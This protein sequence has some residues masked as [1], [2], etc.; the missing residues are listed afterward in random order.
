MIDRLRGFWVRLRRMF[1][2]RESDG[3]LAA[4]M[5]SH[6][7]QETA[8]RI[9]TGEHP[10]T[11]RRRAAAEFGS[12]D[13]RT[14]EVRDARMGAW[15]DDLRIDLRY[16]LR[17]LR[18]SPTF[19]VVTVLILTLGIGS[20]ATIFSIVNEVLWRD[21]PFA[22]S[23]RVVRVAATRKEDGH[24]ANQT[25]SGPLIHAWRER[26]SSFEY[27]AIFS[28]RTTVF[29]HNNRSPRQ[30]RALV[31]SPS[32]YDIVG[33]P[34]QLGR[35]LT[36]EDASPGAEAVAVLSHETWVTDFNRDPSVLDRH[37]TLDAQSHRVIGVLSPEAFLTIL[38]RPEN[39]DF[40]L[41]FLE[42]IERLNRGE[43]YYNVVAKLKPG[44]TV[45]SAHAEMLAVAERIQTE[46]PELSEESLT[47]VVSLQEDRNRLV[48]PAL[49]ATVTLVALLLIST[50]VNGVKLTLVRTISR[51]GE[52]SV[53]SA[54]GASRGRLT[55]QLLAET[56]LLAVLGSI[57]GVLLA[58]WGVNLL[59]R[60]GPPA[61]TAIARFGFDRDAIL[62]ALVVCALTTF[63]ITAASLCR[64][65]SADQAIDTAN[66]ST[67]AGQNQNRLLNG[68]MTAQFAIATAVLVAAGLM[69]V[70]FVRLTSVDPGFQT[71]D[72]LSF[73]ITLPDTDYT[74]HETRVQMFDRIRGQ[75]AALP[76][77][78][79]VT[80]SHAP[81]LSGHS[82]GWGWWFIDGRGEPEP[83]PVQARVVLDDYHATMGIDLIRGRFFDR[84]D[85][86]DASPVV[87][88]NERLAHNH[89]GEEDAIGRSIQFGWQ[90][91]P[92]EVIGIVH[93]V[94]H[95]SLRNEIKAM[96]YVP[97]GQLQ[98]A[99]VA[100]MS[101]V[102]RGT[103]SPTSLVSSISSIVAGIDPGLPLAEVALISDW[104]R[105]AVALEHSILQLLLFFSGVTVLITAVGLYGVVSYLMR[106]RRRELGIRVAVGAQRGQIAALVYQQGARIVLAG[107]AL[108]IFV[109][110]SGTRIISNLLY[111]VDAFA[112][113]VYLG[114]GVVLIT[115]ASIALGLPAWRAT[116]IN[117]TEA[118]RSE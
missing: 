41:P 77:V 83:K 98:T 96:I 116:K 25:T 117:P 114:A 24:S 17:G 12:V 54:L 99:D 80:G 19:S 22:D 18:K 42:P 38:P 108:G 87:I 113:V 36:A 55:R 106:Q 115:A 92:M 57:G 26:T 95:F 78:T 84:R 48:R 3:G 20:A 104:V 118:L 63:A 14:E 45:D 9:A 109:A 50:V 46:R 33:L 52:F 67:T 28:Q 89:F 7:E 8:R 40:L 100:V 64:V 53:R 13:A 111:D 49:W 79:A 102:V 10:A 23:D 94:Q 90:E 6:L 97:A 39:T 4:E 70:S 76:G 93:N 51:E 68:L 1:F 44:V 29:N 30:A 91:K 107:I 85:H 105:E 103:G 15:F 112:P 34:M 2:R 86:A 82:E 65:R 16:A 110:W 32:L 59:A 75:T 81:P 5:Q 71:E 21:L 60:V 56:G 72:R 88:I 47:R 62:F 58:S 69:L 74:D 11:A 101:F 35:R 31:A 27:F 37:I 43:W 61:L 73:R 66:R